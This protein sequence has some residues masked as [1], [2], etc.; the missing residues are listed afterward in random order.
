VAEQG[1]ESDIA[2]HLLPSMPGVVEQDQPLAG[3]AARLF[4]KVAKAEA[5]RGL[6]PAPDSAFNFRPAV[7][8]CLS[9]SLSSP[10]RR[11]TKL[12][13]CYSHPVEGMHGRLPFWAS[14]EVQRATQELRIDIFL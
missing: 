2:Q 1:L 13:Y 8:C 7:R 12:Q 6:A 3:N 9:V 14:Q 11:A 10:T 4:F 5:R